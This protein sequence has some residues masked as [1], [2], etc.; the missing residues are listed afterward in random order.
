MKTLIA[1][2]IAALC[3]SAC[4][5]VPVGPRHRYVEPAPA[6]IVPPPVV[7]PWYGYRDYGYRRHYRP[8]RDYDA[9]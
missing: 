3:L 9:P 4:V 2:S 7:R 6:V 5:V 1:A 8:Y